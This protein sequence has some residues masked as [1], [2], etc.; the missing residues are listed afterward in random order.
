MLNGENT[1]DLGDKLP[2]T[3]CL[4]REISLQVTVVYK[5]KYRQMLGAPKK[6][7]APLSQGVGRL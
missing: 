1:Q 7:E 4:E 2:K 3:H 6:G 5:Q